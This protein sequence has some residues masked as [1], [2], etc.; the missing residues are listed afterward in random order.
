MSNGLNRSHSDLLITMHI[1]YK[2]IRKLRNY[3]ILS[4]K[5]V[6]YG[7]GKEGKQTYYYGTNGVL[8]D[9]SIR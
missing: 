5:K 7:T 1:R 4:T 2:H 6:I 8:I 9:G 3:Q